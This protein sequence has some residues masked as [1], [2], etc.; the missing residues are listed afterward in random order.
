MRENEYFAAKEARKA[1]AA[2]TV[3]MGH[4]FRATLRFASS[5]AT[6]RISHLEA[7]PRHGPIKRADFLKISTTNQ[8][9]NHPPQR[10]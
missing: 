2:G 7:P 3:A 9:T 5:A 4:T 6:H 1:E 10:C 8:P